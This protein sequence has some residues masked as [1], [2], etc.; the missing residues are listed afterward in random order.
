MLQTI[1][2]QRIKEPDCV[3]ENWIAFSPNSKILAVVYSDRIIQQW[4]TNTGVQLQTLKDL[5]GRVRWVV[6]SPNS[7][8]LASVFQDHQIIQLW[9]TAT[10]ALQ[11]TLEENYSCY[12]PITFT[13]DSKLL[14]WVSHDGAVKTWDVASGRLQQQ[15]QL[16]EGVTPSGFSPDRRLLAS[17]SPDGAVQLWDAN[18]DSL[19]HTSKLMG[20]FFSVAVSPDSRLLASSGSLVKV[21][22]LASGKLQQTLVAHSWG[23]R[24]MIF[25]PDS[26]LLALAS[27]SFGGTVELWGLATD[28]DEYDI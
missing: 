3:G 4:A 26:R 13:P 7:E 22:D 9:A 16:L 12:R 15:W 5:D 27:A 2:R 23:V 20:R 19:K 6:F 25:S 17:F 11:H 1:R 28:T 21:W 10:G 24:E 8:M 18:S 14:R